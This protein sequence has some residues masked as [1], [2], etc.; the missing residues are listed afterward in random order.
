MAKRARN[1]AKKRGGENVDCHVSETR[2]GGWGSAD[3]PLCEYCGKPFEPKRRDQKFGN[4]KVERHLHWE[5]KQALVKLVAEL[6]AKLGGRCKTSLQRVA[7]LCVSAAYKQLRQ[8]VARLGYR[9]DQK[10]KVW[11]LQA[12]LEGRNAV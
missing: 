1:T 11:R 5:R 12:R 4:P 2:L 9:Y 10:R 3:F 7:Q 6:L 8:A